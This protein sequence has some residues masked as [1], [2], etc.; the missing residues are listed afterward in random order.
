ME[1]RGGDGQ[2]EA[3]RWHRFV[4]AFL[5]ELPELAGLLADR[6]VEP[7]L[8]PG[9]LWTTISLELLAD[10]YA[11]LRTET[12]VWTRLLRLLEVV[13]ELRD[14]L[15]QATPESED[16]ILT[17]DAFVNAGLLCDITRNRAGLEQLLPWMGPLTPIFTQRIPPYFQVYS[18]R[19]RRPPHHGTAT[20][21][22]SAWRSTGE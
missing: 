17:L 21:G 9:D 16:D 3:R 1:R 13:E 18:N 12:H 6:E 10:D 20:S 5:T 2:A 4:S 19:R 8:T 22:T 15:E 14:L 7:P 11:P